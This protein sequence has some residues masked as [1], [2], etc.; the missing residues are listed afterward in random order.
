MLQKTKLNGFAAPAQIVSNALAK[1]ARAVLA[2]V[3]RGEATLSGFHNHHHELTDGEVDRLITDTI[4]LGRAFDAFDE[5]PVT[6]E[7]RRLMR[8]ARLGPGASAPFF[9]DAAASDTWS[10]THDK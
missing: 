1:A 5:P 2:A 6:N 10:S 8:A 3:R 4:G 7:K 9:R